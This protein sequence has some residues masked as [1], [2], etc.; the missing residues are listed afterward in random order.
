[1]LSAD[2]GKDYSDNKHALHAHNVHNDH[3]QQFQVSLH[4]VWDL[5]C[6]V[7]A[8]VELSCFDQLFGGL[9]GFQHSLDHDLEV[10][11]QNHVSGDH[12]GRDSH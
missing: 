3:F 4:R 10:L 5:H 2:H 8:I 6:V 1:M 12:R 9:N 11:R 7:L